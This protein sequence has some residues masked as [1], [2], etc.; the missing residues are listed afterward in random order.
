MNKYPTPLYLQ[1]KSE[2][3]KENNWKILHA[4]NHPTRR[5]ILKL[6]QEERALSFNELSRCIIVGNHGRLGFHLRALAELVEHEP[7][8]NKYRL[9]DAGRMAI[10]L[11]ED[12]QFTA[13]KIKRN[14]LNAPINYVR[15]LVLGEHSLFLYDTEKLKHEISFS[16]LKEGLLKHQA[17]FY[18]VSENKLD[19]ET[20]QAERYGISFDQIHGGAFTLLSSE[21]WH[22]RKGKAQAKTIIANWSA[23]LKE[24]QT[25]GFEGL[26][27]AGE[28]DVF[29]QNAKSKELL[30]Y[31]RILAQQFPPTVCAICLYSTHVLEENQL[32]QLTKFHDHLI[33]PIFAWKKT[34]TPTAFK[35][36]AQ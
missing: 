18:V 1:L 12:V 3:L 4:I 14:K 24:K 16:F 31:E 35:T 13:E 21:E 26:W 7:S 25:A 15:N 6:L 5:K 8:T 34:Q 30:R 17:A 19:S 33:T 2:P 27:I 20:R 36:H 11:I 23:L 29:F 9:T 10:G 22:L 28:G 32:V